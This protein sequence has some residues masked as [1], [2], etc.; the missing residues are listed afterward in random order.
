MYKQY[1]EM[2]LLQAVEAVVTG[3][4]TQ[5]NAAKFF[6]VPRKTIH[7]RLQKMRERSSS[8]IEND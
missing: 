5:T 4:M 2:S 8:K 7:Y 6:G 1:D 3:R